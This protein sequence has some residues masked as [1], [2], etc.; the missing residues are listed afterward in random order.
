MSVQT[1]SVKRS[2]GTP[3]VIACIGKVAFTSFKLA[4]AVVTRNSDTDR[5]GRSAYHCGHCK[6]WHV[7]T[8]NGKTAKRRSNDFKT[9]ARA[10]AQGGDL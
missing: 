3:A 5:P 6:Q 1:E 2:K 10:E 9:R 4:N 8:D 7:G